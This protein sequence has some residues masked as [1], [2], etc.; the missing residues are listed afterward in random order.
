MPLIVVPTP[1]GN[2]DDMT[3]RGVEEL[4]NADLIV[5][6]DTRRT[7]KL[8]NHYGI[9]K[10]LLACHRHNERERTG[11]IVSRLE[12]GARVA[13]VSDAGTPCVSD[14]GCELIGAA[15]ERGIE[16]DVLPGA[17]A[18]LPALILSGLPARQFTFIGFLGDNKKKRAREAKELSQ[19]Q[20]TL[21]FYA[22]PHDLKETLRF[23]SASLGNRDAAIVREISK[24]HQETIRGTLAELEEI[25]ASREIKGEI[26]LVVR[27]AEAV[28]PMPHDWREEAG[29]MRA[30]G[31][32]DREIA[33]AMSE[34]YGAKRNEV[35]RWLRRADKI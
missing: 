28:E 2:L 1:I 13:L 35:K 11:E 15:I 20:S 25:A 5:C 31:S 12:G 24:I 21:I 16:L 3:I 18:P 4:K 27:G 29:Q 10:P 17:N 30:S 33:D 6:E 7:L 8:L 19:L 23:L 26:V 34:K 9:K 22:A 14:P 32:P